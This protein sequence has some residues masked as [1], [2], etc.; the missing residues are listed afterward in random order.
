MCFTR[1]SPASARCFCGGGETAYN[2]CKPTYLQLG[3]VRCPIQFW[4]ANISQNHCRRSKRQMQFNLSLHICPISI[5]WPR[6][7]QAE[8]HRSSPP[9]PWNGLPTSRSY[10][11][12]IYIEIE[13]SPVDKLSIW[14][15]FK[16]FLECVTIYFNTHHVKNVISNLVISGTERWFRSPW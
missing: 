8:D 14:H 6:P 10:H 11:N 7:T 16:I 9:Y 3:T 15:F 5:F 13:L 2:L 12:Y 4:N 1:L